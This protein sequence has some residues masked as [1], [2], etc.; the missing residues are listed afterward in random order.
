MLKFT[1]DDIVEV[2]GP[3]RP[4]YEKGSDGKFHLKIEGHPDSA[5]LAEFRTTNLTVMRERDALKAQFE[6]IDPV[7]A[8]AALAKLAAGDPDEVVTLRLALATEKGNTAAAQAK[9]SDLIFRQ[10]VG[11]AFVA[12]G[13]RPEAVD[14]IVGRAPFVIVDG[15]LQP[16]EGASSPTVEEWLADQAVTSAFVFLPS[17]GGGAR[18]AKAPTLGTRGTVRELRNPSAQELGAASADIAA[19]RVKVVITT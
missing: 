1:I 8:R 4:E 9:A 3:L 7:A 12:S 17:S 18:G 19:G 11:S 14:Y 5:K 15:E 13:G 2:P 10:K 6:G 16:K